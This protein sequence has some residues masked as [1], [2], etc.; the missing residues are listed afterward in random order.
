MKKILA[1]LFLGFLV[2]S[3]ST[4]ATQDNTT[5]TTQTGDA[6]ATTNQTG[7]EQPD[8]DEIARQQIAAFEA[9]QVKMYTHPVD[10]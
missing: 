2:T 1:A 3:C 5:S 10:N 9:N 7:T 4:T 6:T 8:Q